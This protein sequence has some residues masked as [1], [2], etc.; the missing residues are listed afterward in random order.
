M[1]KNIYATRSSPAL[2]PPTG[3]LERILRNQDLLFRAVYNHE[4][5]RRA[6]SIE[7]FLI[8]P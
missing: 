3:S 2:S 5:H 8:H 4:N 6:G 1:S 7:Q